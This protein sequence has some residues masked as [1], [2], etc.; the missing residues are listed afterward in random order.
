MTDLEQL[1]NR[2]RDATPAELLP[3]GDVDGLFL[4]YALL[5]SAKGL[6]VTARD[7]HDAWRVWMLLRGRPDHKSMVP[8]D[9]LTEEIRLSDI[10][11]VEA[12]HLVSTIAATDLDDAP[13]DSRDDLS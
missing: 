5:C 12:I 11:F 7:V 10:P 8:F 4:L 9:E 13:I 1:A 3:D 6:G 2:V